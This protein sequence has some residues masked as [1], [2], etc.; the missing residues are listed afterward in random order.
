[1]KSLSKPTVKIITNCKDYSQTEY[2]KKKEY[3]SP[4]Y[5]GV[6]ILELGI[7]NIVMYSIIFLN[8]LSKI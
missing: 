8:H 6:T 5:V 4:I 3:G 1:M 7:L 2:T